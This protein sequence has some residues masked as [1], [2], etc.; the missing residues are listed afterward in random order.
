MKL[1]KKQFKINDNLYIET[2]DDINGGTYVKVIQR[3]GSVKQGYAEIK[4]EKDENYNIVSKRDNQIVMFFKKYER[5]LIDITLLEQLDKQDHG[6]TEN[7]YTI[8]KI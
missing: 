6:F 1:N 4:G 3:N 2:G 5:A 8:E 7:N